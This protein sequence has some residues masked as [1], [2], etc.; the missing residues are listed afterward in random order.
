M[1]NENG[2]EMPEDCAAMQIEGVQFRAPGVPEAERDNTLGPQEGNY[3]MA[4][5]RAP[6]INNVL[7]PKKDQAGRVMKNKELNEYLYEKTVTEDTVP[8]FDYLFANGININSYPCEWFD[9]F[10]PMWRKR[11]DNSNKVSVEDLTTWTNIKALLC[12]AGKGGGAY[13]RFVS[14]TIPDVAKHLGLY[15]LNGI[16][17]TPQVELKFASQLEDPVNGNDLC[18]EVFNGKEGA[19]RHREFK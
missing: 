17:P 7:L 9:I 14:F 5:D 11:H 18:H 13:S 19:R 12:N 6:L 4:F 16:S 1:S 3:E 15:I 10:M 8:N 2:E